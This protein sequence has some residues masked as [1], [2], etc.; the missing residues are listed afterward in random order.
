MTKL[1]KLVEKLKKE[2][3]ETVNSIFLANN[4]ISLECEVGR[5]REVL[6]QLQTQDTFAFDQLI[7][8]CGVDY[9][10]YGEY[11][12]ETESAT[13][14]GFSRGVEK[15]DFRAYVLDRP[16]FAVVYHLLSTT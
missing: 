16:R 9:L 1:T 12:W 6:G 8:L 4:E 13:E 3:G 2:L 14:G 15:Q 7:D 5:I 10:H 11:D